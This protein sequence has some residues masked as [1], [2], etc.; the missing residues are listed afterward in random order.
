MKTIIN[1]MEIEGTPSE[2]KEFMDLCEK[3][4]KIKAEPVKEFKKTIVPP[5]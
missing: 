1:G 5:A 4:K 2:L 3:P